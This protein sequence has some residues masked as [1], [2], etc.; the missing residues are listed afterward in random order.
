MSMLLVLVSGFWCLC[1]FSIH[2]CRHWEIPPLWNGAMMEQILS[3]FLFHV[4]VYYVLFPASHP[5]S[6]G[7]F[8]SSH[9]TLN[10]IGIIVD[11]WIMYYFLF[12]L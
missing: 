11:G 5:K 4:V 1:L 7:M 10:R 12:F 8:S 9:A 3:D 6:A 2:L